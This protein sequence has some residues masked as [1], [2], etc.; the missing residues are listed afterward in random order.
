[1]LPAYREPEQAK[2]RYGSAYERV[3][4]TDCSA[5]H[6]KECVCGPAP[7]TVTAGCDSVVYDP[8]A[9]TLSCSSSG[10]YY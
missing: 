4:E 6:S 5:E 9:N 3:V 10:G 2:P 1:M 8:C 7:L